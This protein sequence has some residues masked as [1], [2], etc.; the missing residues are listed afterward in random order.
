[1]S[2]RNSMIFSIGIRGIALPRLDLF[3]TAIRRVHP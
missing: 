2:R 1:M 3:S